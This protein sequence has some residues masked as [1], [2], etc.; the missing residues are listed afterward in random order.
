LDRFLF[1]YYYI[2]LDKY[3][4]SQR[5]ENVPTIENKVI[6]IL[7]ERGYINNTETS[8]FESA[9]RTDRYVSAR[10]AVFAINSLKDPILMEINAHLPNE[11]GLWAYSKVSDDFSPR[12]EAQLRHYRYIVP[13]PLSYLKEQFDFDLSILKKACEQ[14]EGR[15]DFQNFSKRASNTNNTVRNMK[16]INLSISNNT[17]LINFKSQAFLWQQ[18]RRIA[19][20]LIE[21][22]KGEIQYKD[23]MALL[24]PS[25][26]KSYQPA[27]PKGLIL[28]DIKYD[29]D[30]VEFKIDKK[31][32]ERM[33][34]YFTN[35]KMQSFVQYK[36]FSIMQDR[37]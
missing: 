21:L 5:Q 13:Y 22:G 18:I 9:S 14:L 4:G 34:E 32:I 12:Y 15:H 29:S 11:I 31:S 20:K 30:I 33:K 1:K 16:S 37:I 17:L 6:E 10:G 35:R 8:Q 25:E 3:H 7:K 28:W 19:R 36:L 2:A 27:N 23:F 26:F 24:N